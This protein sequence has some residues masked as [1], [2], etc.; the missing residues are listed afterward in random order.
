MGGGKRMRST[1]EVR[2][3][4]WMRAILCL[5]RVIRR[6]VLFLHE[7]LP[8][9]PYAEAMG[10]G[11]MPESL[12]FSLRG[13]LECLLND[14]IEP[15]IETLQRAVDAHPEGLVREWEALKPLRQDARPSAAKPTPTPRNSKKE[16][17]N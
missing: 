17:E 12:A 14:R 11:R 2:T 8:D 15:A 9:S 5:F 7:R 3:Q 16:Q 1:A 6:S 4:R 13:D 10:E